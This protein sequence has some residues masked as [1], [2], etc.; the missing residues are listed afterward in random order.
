MIPT[1]LRAKQVYF[2][3]FGERDVCFFP[4]R[5][6]SPLSAKAFLFAFDVH[7]PDACALDLEKLFDGRLDLFF[8][9][10]ARNFEDHLV[11]RLRQQR[12]LL[13]HVRPAQ[14]L[15]DALFV[16]PSHSSTWRS[17]PTVITTCS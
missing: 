7:H 14:H 2:M 4:V 17:A 9:R 1:A 13:R 6:T 15:K 10:V 8:G 16:H 3:T 5:S 12:A 11:L